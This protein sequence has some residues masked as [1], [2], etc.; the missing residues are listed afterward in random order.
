MMFVWANF[1]VFLLHGNFYGVVTLFFFFMDIFMLSEI[2]F[3]VREKFHA[4]VNLFFCPW[5]LRCS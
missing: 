5:R 3:F 2:L 4:L 1:L